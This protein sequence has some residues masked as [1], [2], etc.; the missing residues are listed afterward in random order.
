MSVSDSRESCASS[1]CLRAVRVCGAACRALSHVV[2]VRRVC[3]LHVS[4]AL[5]RV[6][7][8]LITCVARRLRVIIIVFAYKHLC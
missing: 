7:H 2:Y 1:H 8:V 3:H 5:S 6:S 4:L